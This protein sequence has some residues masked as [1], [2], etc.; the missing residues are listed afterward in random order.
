MANAGSETEFLRHYNPDQYKKPTVMVDISIFT[1]RD[2]QLQVLLIKRGGHPFKGMWSLPGGAVHVD[3]SGKYSF[4]HSLE[5]AAR[6]ELREETGIDSRYL[7]QVQT[8]G[9]ATRD[10]RDWTISVSY[11]ALMDSNLMTLRHGSDAA[12]AKWH[13]V[14]D[15]GVRVKLAFDHKTILHDAIQRLRSKVEYTPIAACLLPKEFTLPQL[16]RTYEI[17]LQESIQNKSFRR[18]IEDSDVIV[19]T[20]KVDD[21]AKGRKPQLYKYKPGKELTLFFP[22]SIVWAEHN[23]GEV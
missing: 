6:R 7:E 1:V 14:H 20:G 2:E 8:Y 17:L 3:K 9:N 12:E 16:K 15:N 21:Q 5:D 19:P 13:T 22:R 18:R 10:P 23:R 11:F 4:D